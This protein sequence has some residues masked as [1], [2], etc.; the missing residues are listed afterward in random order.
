MICTNLF[1]KSQIIILNMLFL[2]DYQ[3][4]M[5]GRL[6]GAWRKHRRVM[7][8]MPTGTGK[9]HLMA[10][11]IREAADDGVLIVAHRQ[12]LICQI[13]QT[14]EAFGIGHGVKYANV[15]RGGD[16]SSTVQVASIQTLNRRMEKVK[17][18]FGLVIID[19]AHHAL[20]KTYRMLWE[21]WPKAKFLGLTATPCRLS[22]E[23]FTD[24]FDVLL[25]SWSIQ[26]FID[27]G[28]LSDFE[29]VS[30][31]PDSKMVRLVRGLKKRGTDGDYQTAEMAQVMDVPES[32]EHLYRTYR[33]FASG[34][35]GIVYAIDRNHA[36]HIGAYYKD[37]GVDC[38]VIDC[39]TPAEERRRMVTEYLEGRLSVLI[40]VDLFGEGFD[41]P[42][43]EF[44]QLARPTLSL[45]KYLQQ[46]GRGMRISKGKERVTIL[47][48]V[49][50]YQLFGLPTVDRDWKQAFLGREAGKGTQ[51][52][53]R[54]VVIEQENTP[55]QADELALLEMV[56]IKKS[57]KRRTGLEVFM[58]DGR[59]GVMRNGR[60][61]C[62]AKFRR[63]ERL[64]RNCGF[65]ALG[66]YRKRSDTE[67]DRIVDVTTVIDKKGQD[68]NVR[69]YGSVRW[70]DGYFRG[71]EQSENYFFMNCWDPVGNSYYDCDPEFRKV[72]G[73][74]IGYAKDHHGGDFH[75]WKLRCSTGSVSPRFEEEEMFYNKDII[76]ARDYLIVKHDKNHSYHICGYLDNSV[77]VNSDEQYGYQQIWLDGQ[78][79]KLFASLPRGVSRI[80]NAKQLGLQRPK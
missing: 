22:G 54:C 38:E 46:V 68:L 67:P 5:L 75:C 61:S 31:T 53:E 69:L 71:E 59:Y 52:L 15:E 41:A 43:V 9:T 62:P 33:Q 64:D 25:Q 47:D 66:I 18:E 26:E 32:I 6:H 3:A 39:K 45:S 24:L 76:I 34:R 55:E 65:F 35:K 30:A 77:L 58:Q 10:A 21:R 57:G 63:I 50:L 28:W 79:G 29:Y 56:R 74:E 48:N 13:S 49:G 78:K 73:V 37:R 80:L 36:A 40:S 2:R 1:K 16:L 14:L 4:E 20:A 12:E 51:G 70:A 19:E 23:P 72:A 17:D 8:Q 7:V 60:I 42:E 27:K 44:I 11:V